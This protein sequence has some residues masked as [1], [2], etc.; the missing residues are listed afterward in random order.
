M[1]NI[2]KLFGC[3]VFTID[4]FGSIILYFPNN[5]LKEIL[6]NQ[7]FSLVTAAIVLLLTIIAEKNYRRV[8][9]F[10]DKTFQF[11]KS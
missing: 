10:I 2:T 5:P 4:F 6:T 1:K 11:I 3:V 7:L 8:G 9:K